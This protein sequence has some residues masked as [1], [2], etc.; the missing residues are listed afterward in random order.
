[1]ALAWS[2]GIG[3]LLVWEFLM[4]STNIFCG[5]H[6]FARELTIAA[7]A[8]SPKIARKSYRLAFLALSSCGA[9][10]IS[11]R[12]VINKRR[13]FVS[14]IFS[15]CGTIGALQKIIPPALFAADV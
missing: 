12:T 14:R 4:V 8:D 5:F 10:F 2:R 13:I 7:W 1:M 11:N 3:L 15:Y 6:C 9:L